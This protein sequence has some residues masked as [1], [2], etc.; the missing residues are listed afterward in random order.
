MSDPEHLAEVSRQFAFPGKFASAAHWGT[1]HIQDSY[2]VEY[3]DGD[4]R[5]RYLL[6]RIARG[7]FKDVQALME[8]I[9]RV[10]AY[11]ATQLTDV[12]DRERRV[13]TLVRA[14]DGRLWHED[15]DGESWRAFRWVEGTHTYET[16]ESAEQAFQVAR[17]FGRFQAAL[18]A[19]P[20][21]RLHETIPDFHNTPK[22]LAALERAIALDEAGRVG[23][24]T[25]EIEFA[26]ARR[27][28]AGVLTQ[29]NLPERI[30]H[31]DTKLNNVLF[32]D[33]T[34][35]GICVIDLDTVMPGLAPCDFGDMVRTATSPAAEDERDL[36]RVAMRL[37]MFEALLRG[38]LSTAGAVLTEAEKLLLATAGKLIT[39][40][41]GIR[42]LTD[43]LA[44]D[45]YYKVHREGHNL[46][47]CRTQFKLVESMEQ[48]EDEMERLVCA[49]Q[50]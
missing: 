24:A 2:C 43:Y 4:A 25:R 41:Q 29:A 39:W 31:N 44:G 18:A 26:L 10:T 12:R 23:N 8:N 40:E 34:G 20:G 36:S 46:E 21:P 6:Q 35:E 1:G 5:R 42:F 22:R 16:A 50:K 45:R 32:D 13:L 30:T 14:R 11:M 33:S 27:G 48:Q 19:M 17:A 38:Y 49:V 37:L 7:V 3:R 9:E 28:L 47:R 15:K